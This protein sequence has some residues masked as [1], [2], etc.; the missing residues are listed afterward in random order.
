[1]LLFLLL[2]A[3]P[4][5]EGDALVWDK[6]EDDDDILGTF[7]VYL[8]K[9]SKIRIQLINRLERKKKKEK[10]RFLG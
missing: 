3:V 7:L 4:V 9:Y 5:V 10:G 2:V 8:E 1:M 6:A